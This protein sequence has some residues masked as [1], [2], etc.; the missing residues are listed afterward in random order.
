MAEEQ[1]RVQ[2]LNPFLEWHLHTTAMSLETASSE[3]T[4]I[5]GMIGRKIRVLGEDG[6]VLLEVNAITDTPD[7][8]TNPL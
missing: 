6:S 8:V 1:F 5:A 3:A 2:E 7:P 4:R